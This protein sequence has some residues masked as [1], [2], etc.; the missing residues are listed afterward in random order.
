MS[1]ARSYPS[2]SDVLDSNRSSNTAL[3]DATRPGDGMVFS[4]K[5][6]AATDFPTRKRRTTARWD[7]DA[8]KQMKFRSPARNEN[9]AF[10][11]KNWRGSAF[12]CTIGS[13]NVIRYSQRN[14]ATYTIYFCSSA[15]RVVALYYSQCKRKNTFPKY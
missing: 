15:N 1:P 8:H 10:F 6:H 14:I 2:S 4:I 5:R 3:P 13:I 9:V 7:Y 12:P 11:S